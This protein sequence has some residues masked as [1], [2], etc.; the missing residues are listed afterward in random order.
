MFSLLSYS[1]ADIKAQANNKLILLS[2]SLY[3]LNEMKKET[4]MIIQEMKNLNEIV[5]LNEQNY[6]LLDDYFKYSGMVEV[7]SKLITMTPLY[8]Q[9]DINKVTRVYNDMSKY[10]L[11]D[12]RKYE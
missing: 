11:K 12:Y 4:K 6:I 7:N 3:K 1:E 8:R 2:V 5:S 9:K 10:K